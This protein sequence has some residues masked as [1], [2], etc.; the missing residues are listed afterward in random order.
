MKS[1]LNKLHLLDVNPGACTGTD[2]WIDPA[3]KLISYNPTTNEPIAAV[4]QAT[5]ASYQKVVEQ[6]AAAFKT[7]RTIPAPGAVKSSAI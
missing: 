1:L 5:P 2:G 6:A 7:W 3:G 4:V